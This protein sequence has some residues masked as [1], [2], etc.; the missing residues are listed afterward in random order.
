L[1]QTPTHPPTPP[2][3]LVVSCFFRVLI[4]TFVT[5]WIS[6]ATLGY[7]GLAWAIMLTG[8]SLSEHVGARACFIFVCQN[9][10]IF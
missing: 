8:T 10:R 7:L 1:S 3:P 5:F 2:R 4:M 9:F 6:W